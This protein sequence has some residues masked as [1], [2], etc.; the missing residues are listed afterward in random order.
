MEGSE[1]LD[2]IK[3]S[4][5]GL[6]D[7]PSL[8]RN[9]DD[10]SVIDEISDESSSCCLVDVGGL[11]TCSISVLYYQFRLKPIVIISRVIDWAWICH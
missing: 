10:H 3:R 8:L 7:E 1:L 6:I 2:R 9:R 4:I 5:T 11:D